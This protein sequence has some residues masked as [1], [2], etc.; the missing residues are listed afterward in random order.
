LTAPE[1]EEEALPAKLIKPRHDG[2]QAVFG[3]MPSDVAEYRTAVRLDRAKRRDELLKNRAVW[4]SDEPVLGVY[5]MDLK[6]GDVVYALVRLLQGPFAGKLMSVEK[7]FVGESVTVQLVSYPQRPL[8]SFDPVKPTASSPKPYA[9]SGGGGSRGRGG[10][11]YLPAIGWS[12][13]KTVYVRGYYRKNGT[14]VRPHY[15][16]PPRRR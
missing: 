9:G 2:E 12:P 3:L 16:S 6:A 14:Y 4:L 13:A 5:E 7:R 11:V 15:R 10:P 1:S 8:R